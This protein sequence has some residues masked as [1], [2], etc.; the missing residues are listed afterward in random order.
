MSNFWKR[1]LTGILFVVIVAGAIVWN[2]I[3]FI[4]LF[5]VVGVLCL[6]EFYQLF[7]IGK[8]YKISGIITGIFIYLIPAM[9]VNEIFFKISLY[10]IIPSLSVIII[11]STLFIKK[12]KPFDEVFKVIFGWIYFIIPFAL[13]T[14]V[15]ILPG[16]YDY[17]FVLALMMIVWV[18]DT[19]AY[20]TGSI[21][22]K[23]KLFELISPKKTWEGFFGGMLFSIIFAF[24]N[25]YLFGKTSLINWILL[26]GIVSVFATIG[27]LIESQM[28]RSLNVKDSGNLIPGHGGILDRFDGVIFATPFYFIYLILSGLLIN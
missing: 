9:V 17:R 27:D 26:S 24:V 28:K 2:S 18:N 13:L 15:G 7:R 11:A 6:N 23:H 14:L 8:F 4:V 25:Y 12:E 5:G 21:F 10:I 20:I 19:M 22:G 3:S 1:T 16:K